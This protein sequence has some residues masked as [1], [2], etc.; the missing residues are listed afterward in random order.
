RVLLSEPD[1]LLLDEPSNYL[2][3][4]AVEWLQ[5][6]L[7][8]YT[9]TLL[10]ISHDRFL[11]NS[12]TN[13]TLEINGGK[14]TR[15]SG[16]YSKYVVERET[17]SA[18]AEAARKNTEKRR[19]K[20]KENIERFRYKASK[21]AQV[22]MWIKMLDKIET[23]ELPEQLH[24]QGR[25]RIPEP[26]RCGAEVCAVE[27][28]SHSYDGARFVFRDVSFSINNGDKL[29]IVGY[30]GM[31]KTTLLRIIAGTLAPTSGRA[32]LGHN[33]VIG[34]QAQEFAELLPA[35][36]A[37]YDVVKHAAPGDTPPSRIR[38][39]L[40]AFGFSGD[41]AMKQCKVLS[42]GEKIRLC[43]A[44]IFV[45][46]PNLLILDE[47]TTHL[48]IAARE[49][50][51]DAIMN[52]K[53]TVCFVSHD[54]E[55][56]RGTAT[57]ILEMRHDRVK[58]FF[59]GFDYYKEKLAEEEA[60]NAPAPASQ[61]KSNA[62]AQTASNVNSA[63]AGGQSQPQTAGKDRRREKAAKRN[64]LLPEK[65]RIERG[66]AKCEKIIEDAENEKAEID[67]Q[68]M[69]ATPQTDFAALQKRRKALDYDIAEATVEWERLASEH[70]E[71]MKQYTADAD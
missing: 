60:A 66:L 6:R 52:Y 33:V 68:L 65:R 40:G 15:Y 39:I 67:K 57:S 8:V 27:N 58:R 32:R 55:F 43:F 51:Q 34:Y 47:P 21:A 25:I 31:G 38:E 4:P 23:E 42:G 5:R 59:G 63:G 41:D 22:Q 19:D 53:G 18:L 11:L 24:F 54:L 44:R 17:R 71:F 69:E 26:P 3:I 56:I 48:D 70:E 62:A 46:P 9:G 61:T 14:A 12:L 7:R 36:E 16:S 28:V 30:N 20:L 50:L 2:D 1:I 10:L 64:A 29:G 49:A 13:V 45:N 37:A 35:E